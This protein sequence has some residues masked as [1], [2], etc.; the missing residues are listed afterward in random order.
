VEQL[1]K[2]LP[3]FAFVVAAVLTLGV[4][5]LAFTQEA[6]RAPL[7]EPAADVT[8]PSA[9]PDSAREPG[10]VV[11]DPPPSASAVA[12]SSPQSPSAAPPPPP[13]RSPSPVL[14]V[15]VLMYHYI[16]AVPPEQ[17]ND[18]FAVDLRVPPDLFEQHLVYLESHGYTTISVPRLW[19]ALNGG[20]ALPERPVILTFDDGYADAYTNA[21]P[22]LRKHRVVGTFFVTCNL[23]GRPGYMTWDQVRELDAA[24]MDIQ[25]HAMDHKPMSAFTLAG[26]AYQMGQARATLAQHLGHEVRFFAYPAGDYNATA[27]NGL[28]ANGY[29]AAFL[30]SG[31]SS[32]SADWRYQLRRARV[33]GYAGVDTFAAALRY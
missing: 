9:L 5:A 26:L 29:Y 20:A 13:T 10:A 17:A 31:G 6:A 32:Q 23:I 15:P 33:T 28:V 8:L 7:V 14:R 30:K 16:S 4:S 24:G 1:V 18:R 21:F 2:R 27:I 11:T 12:V 3:F 19:D 22:L 25:S